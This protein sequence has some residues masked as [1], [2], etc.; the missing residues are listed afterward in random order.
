MSLYEVLLAEVMLRK[1]SAEQ[2]LSVFEAFVEQYP[3]PAALADASEEE[4]ERAR[5]GDVRAVLAGANVPSV[6]VRN[7]YERESTRAAWY[8]SNAPARTG[9]SAGAGTGDVL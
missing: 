9:P 5:R 2:V 7:G 4:V 1:T 8:P 6:A 3:D